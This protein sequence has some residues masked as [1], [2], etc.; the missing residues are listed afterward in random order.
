LDGG[1][2]RK[3]VDGG[4][5]SSDFFEHE[6]VGDGSRPGHPSFGDIMPQQ[7]RAAACGFLGGKFSWRSRWVTGG[8][9]LHFHEL[10][11]RI[12]NQFL[13]VAERKNPSVLVYIRGCIR[14][15]TQESGA[16][17]LSIM[18]GEMRESV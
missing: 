4:H 9:H 3:V 7:P 12:A 13:V 10:A 2:G 18:H 8:A 17:N 16:P 1:I 14:D 11:D 15:A 5:R 6:D